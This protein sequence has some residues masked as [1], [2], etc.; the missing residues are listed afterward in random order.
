MATYFGMVRIDMDYGESA[1]VTMCVFLY[2]SDDS[3]CQ[4]AFCLGSLPFSFRFSVFGVWTSY[5]RILRSFAS[6]ISTEF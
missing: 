1:V 2:I 4:E 3:L 6:N 5:F